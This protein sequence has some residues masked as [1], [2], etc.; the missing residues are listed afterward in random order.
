[1]LRSEYPNM[2]W[3]VFSISTLS[4]RCIYT[5]I[6]TIGYLVN[7]C[8]NNYF[9]LLYYMNAYKFMKMQASR[10]MRISLDQ[11]LQNLALNPSL[12]EQL[13]E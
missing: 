12:L 9:I 7:L 1:M 11:A 4:P 8:N 13:I 5:S 6:R 2:V 3:L 10:N